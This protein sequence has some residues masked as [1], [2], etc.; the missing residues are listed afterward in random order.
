M[1]TPYGATVT[2]IAVPD[3]Y[4]PN[5]LIQYKDIDREQVTFPI[6][7]VVDLEWLL[8]NAKHT[9]SEYRR[10]SNLVNGLGDKVIEWVNPNYN[11]EDVIRELCEYF[12]ISPVKQV[13]VTGTISFELTVDVPLDEV[14]DFD[15]HYY[16]Q[17][18]LVLDS[19]S[20]SID[21]NTWSIENSDVDW[22]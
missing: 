18:E 4:N 22:D 21:I 1:E 14:E 15:A 17:D 11:K 7:K 8:E 9:K 5:A 3:T 10:L 2:P 16:L 20:S 6:T 13:V 12:G 19:H